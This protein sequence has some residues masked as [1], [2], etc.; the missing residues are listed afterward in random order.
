M[1]KITAIDEEFFFDGDVIISQTDSDGIITY[2]NKA[3]C[4]VSGYKVEELVGEAH[5]IVRHPDM[6]K[7]VFAKMWETISGGQAWT[8]LVK[9]LRKDGKFYWVDTEILPVVDDEENITGYI[10]ARKEASRK[11]I[12][13]TQETYNKMLEAQ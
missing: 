2:A 4:K 3:F 13:E 9:N 12:Q 6:P 7:A 5:S 1:E 10:A 11:N 8:G